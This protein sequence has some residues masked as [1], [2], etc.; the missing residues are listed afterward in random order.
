MVIKRL[1]CLTVGFMVGSSAILNIK[2][3]RQWSDTNILDILPHQQ[4]K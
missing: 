2:L 4:E 3:A 1:L